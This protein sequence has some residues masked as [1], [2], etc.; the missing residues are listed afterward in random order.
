VGVTTPQRGNQRDGAKKS[1]SFITSSADDTELADEQAPAAQT[2]VSNVNKPQE[3]SL[4][5]DWGIED[6]GNAI[7]F[8]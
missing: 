2:D 4:D 5:I 6:D 8:V 3:S 1:G 7:D